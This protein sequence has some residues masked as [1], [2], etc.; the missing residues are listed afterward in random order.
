M[1]NFEIAEDE[2]YS[3][4]RRF[5]QLK[6]NREYFRKKNNVLQAFIKLLGN[7]NDNNS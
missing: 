1:T 7:H 4:R 5:G 3:I 2:Y 6:S